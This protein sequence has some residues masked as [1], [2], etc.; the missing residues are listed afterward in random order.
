MLLRV[1]FLLLMVMSLGAVGVVV[2]NLPSGEPVPVAVAEPA[3]PARSAILVAARALPTGTLLRPE[4]VRWEDWPLKGVPE[5]Y[6]ERGRTTAEA[7]GAVNRRPFVAGEPLVLGQLVL[8]NE[9]GFLAAVLT[10]GKRAVAVA[11]DAVSAASGL[12]SPGDRVDLILAQTFDKDSAAPGRGAVGETLL[13]DLRV[14]SI[15]QH[16][17]DAAVDRNTGAPAVPR[18]VSLEVTAKQAEAIAV[19]SGLGRLSLVLR[20]LG[21]TEAVQ[22]PEA[23]VSSTWAEE[24]SP[25][26]GARRAAKPEPSRDGTGM[27]IVRGSQ[28]TIHTGSHTGG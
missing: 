3:V 13:R 23:D 21:A 24:V 16:L 25:A 1:L 22:P 2:L 28:R 10:P 27:L 9:R 19:A 12:I 14:L 4:D 11:V 5:G 17:G 8:P 15:D 7:V 26:L 18:T 20:S 6:I